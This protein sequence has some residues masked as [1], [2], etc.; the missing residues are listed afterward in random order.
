ML[1]PNLLQAAMKQFGATSPEKQ[2]PKTPRNKARRKMA[3]ASKRQ[4]RR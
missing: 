2:K 4:N 3:K 1:S